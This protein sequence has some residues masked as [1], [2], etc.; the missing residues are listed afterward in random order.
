MTPRTSQSKRFSRGSRRIAATSTLPLALATAVVALLAV[1]VLTAFVSPLSP[2][3]ATSRLDCGSRSCHTNDVGDVRTASP[4]QAT[5]DRPSGSVSCVESAGCFFGARL[6][7]SGRQVSD[8]PVAVVVGKALVRPSHLVLEIHPRPSVPVKV[9]WIVFCT[10]S[11]PITGANWRFSQPSHRRLELPP[12]PRGHC[13]FDLEANFAD[14]TQAGHIGL[15]LR[16]R[17]QG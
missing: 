3:G 7:A 14:E 10:E 1:L 11:D 8:R 9:V 17:E 15:R 2:A 12:R 13:F 6:L 16:G 5:R 4:A